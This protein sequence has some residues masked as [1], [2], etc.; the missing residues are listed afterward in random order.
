MF[1]M[2]TQKKPKRIASEID[3]SVGAKVIIHEDVVGKVVHLEQVFLHFIRG[4]WPTPDPNTPV[5]WKYHQ[6]SNFLVW[7]F[8]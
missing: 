6:S 2:S 4:F 1:W 8:Y 3:M 5:V 7:S